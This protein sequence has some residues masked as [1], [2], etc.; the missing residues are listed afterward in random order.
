MGP[1]LIKLTFKHLDENL[2]KYKEK[3]DKRAFK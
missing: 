1:D 2:A 3:E